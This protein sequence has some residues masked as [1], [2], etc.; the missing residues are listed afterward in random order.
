MKPVMSRI[1]V[2]ALA[3]FTVSALSA[4]PEI[5]RLGTTAVDEV[6]SNPIVFKG[7]PYI[8][9]HSRWR[10]LRVRRYPDLAV[11]TPR[12]KADLMMPCAYVEGDRVYVTGTRKD[13]ENQHGTYLIESDDLKS[14]TQAREIVS[15]LSNVAYNTTMTKADGR[16][17]LATERAPGKDEKRTNGG[18]QM[19]FAESTDLKTWRK[20]PGTTYINNAGSPCL[21]YHGGWFY[22]FSLFEKCRTAENKP[23]Y[24]MQVARSKDLVNWTVAK[25]TVLEPSPDDRRPY[26]GIAF[27]ADELAK[28]A[29]AEDRNA[30]DIDMCEVDGDLL[31]TYS[32]GNQLGNEFLALALV[33]GMTE[34][35]FCESFFE[36]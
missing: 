28:M 6:E 19:T 25:R 1:V 30:S 20:I 23:F 7:V 36:E 8:F 14:W 10:S 26:P 33:K 32:W 18:Y 17:V 4:A 9:E 12:F 29:S 24:C 11:V 15:N 16:W 13:A 22:F 31:I 3:A 5:I 2:S 34:R 27:T 35:A 21:R